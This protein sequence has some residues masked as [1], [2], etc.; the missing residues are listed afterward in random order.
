MSR[1]Q[2]S[3]NKTWEKL[4]SSQG[5]GRPVAHFDRPVRVAVVDTGAAIEAS[6]LDIYDN[7]LIECRSWIGKDPGRLV[8]NTTADEVGHG[9]HATSSVLKVTEN[10]DIEVYVAQ[11]FDTDPQHKTLD[12]RAP[13]SMAEAIAQVSLETE[14]FIP[15]STNSSEGNRV[16]GTAVGGRHNIHLLRHEP[17]C[18]RPRNCRRRAC[19]QGSLLRCCIKLRRQRIWNQLASKT[20]QC[21]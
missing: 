19:A 16:C 2:T 10:T 18:R 5:K 8:T 13:G 17:S 9:T 7:R 3:T 4:P 14:G 21:H 11:V 12:M 15:A 6:D 1:L 20:R